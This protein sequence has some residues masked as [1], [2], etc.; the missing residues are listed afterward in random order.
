MAAEPFRRRILRDKGIGIV[1]QGKKKVGLCPAGALVGVYHGDS[2]EKMPGIYHKGGQGSGQEICAAGQQTD[3]H[4]LHGT[5]IDEQTHGAGPER[6]VAALLHDDAEAEAKEEITGHNRNS[7]QKRGVNRFLFHNYQLFSEVF[8][9]RE[10]GANRW[11]II[12]LYEIRCPLSIFNKKTEYE[13]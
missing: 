1:G 2:V 13:T 12:K 6:A 3:S 5:G 4:V 8:P 11:H 9:L 10:R 7:I